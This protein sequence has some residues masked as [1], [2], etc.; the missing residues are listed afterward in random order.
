MAYS[1]FKKKV[2]RKAKRTKFT[3]KVKKVVNSM[4][5]KK[6]LNTNYTPAPAAARAWTFNSALIGITPGNTASTRIGNKIRVTAIHFTVMIEPLLA[7]STT[8]TNGGCVCRF[9]IYHNKQ[10]N[11]TLV[12]GDQMFVTDTLLANRNVDYLSKLS[13]L[14]DVTY[15]MY[16]SAADSTGTRATGPPIV[17]KCSIY[18]NKVIDYV[19]NTAAIS[20]IMKDDYGFGF[21][22]DSDTACQLNLNVQTVYTDA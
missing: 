1:S 8:I 9:I 17:F 15:P 20:S 19:A 12:T 16:I 21:S 7:G 22:S 2:F 10:T 4:V 3:T 6:Y 18:P 11:G 14:K 5:E 13:V